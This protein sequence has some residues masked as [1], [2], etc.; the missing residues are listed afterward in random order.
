MLLSTCPGLGKLM[1][2]ECEAG[3]LDLGL[4]LE[5]DASMASGS[6]GL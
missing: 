2:D 3:P 5:E 4:F 1:L 6:A